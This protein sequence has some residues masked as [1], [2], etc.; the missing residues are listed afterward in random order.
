MNDPELVD[1]ARRWLRFAAEDID[2]AQR[3]LATDGPTVRH[4]CFLAQQ[5][6]EKALKAALVLE[7][8]D[9]PFRHDLD[10]LRNLLPDTWSVRRTHT[11][12]AQLTEWAVEARYP[13]DWQEAT[14]TDAEQA[15]S[16]AREVYNSIA[17][18]FE[19]CTNRGERC[20]KSG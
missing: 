12:L 3:L 7:G 15:V 16:Q 20:S 6:A 8:I 14:A 9:F 5:A 19:R 10:A 2:V 18:D 4:T 17:A 11:D 1:E 13:G